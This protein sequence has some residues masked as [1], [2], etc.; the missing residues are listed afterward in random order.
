[1]YGI[2]EL[3]EVLSLETYHENQYICKDKLL[4]DILEKFV[5][6]RSL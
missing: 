3:E 1:S 5:W 6:V 4:Y 2:H